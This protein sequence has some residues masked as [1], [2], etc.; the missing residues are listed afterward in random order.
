M[1]KATN[2]PKPSP[3]N[4]QPNFNAEKDAF[5]TEDKF[6]LFPNI[7]GVNFSPIFSIISNRSFLHTNNSNNL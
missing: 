5:P 7:S 4:K 3:T 6:I 1:Q 2:K